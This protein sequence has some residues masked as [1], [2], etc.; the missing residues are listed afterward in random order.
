[1]VYNYVLRFTFY[2][3]A[4]VIVAKK[5]IGVDA[6]GPLGLTIALLCT[7]LVGF[8]IVLVLGKNT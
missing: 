7:M 2:L 8:W 5:E 6:F 1:M 3:G 4:I